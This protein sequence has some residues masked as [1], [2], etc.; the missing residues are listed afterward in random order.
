M[1]V[2]EGKGLGLWLGEQFNDPASRRHT[3]TATVIRTVLHSDSAPILDQGNLGA[4][5][6]F[7]DADILNCA[8]FVG[9]RRR[10]DK[11]GRYIN[12]LTGRA[13]YHEATVRDEWTDETWE[14]DDTGSSVLAGAKALKDLG[15]IDR[16]E[17]AW[18]MDGFLAA[19]TRQPVMLGTLWTEGMFD[20]DAKGLIRPTG[21]LVG[22]HAYIA[23]GLNT[24]KRLVRCRNHWTSDWG[25][26]GE[27]YLSFDDVAWLIEQQGEVLVPIPV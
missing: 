13:F 27:F 19:L 18:D 14:P 5:V 15:Y 2:Y 4:C 10:R 22:G 26:R 21:D 7:T 8:K 17:W 12:N 24:S 16:Y 3:T 6:G 1:Q 23:R 9:S 25:V 11:R 20:P